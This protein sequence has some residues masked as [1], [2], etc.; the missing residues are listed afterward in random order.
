[1]NVLNGYSKG[2]GSVPRSPI[3]NFE[4]S[5]VTE[6]MINSS[7]LSSELDPPD[8]EVVQLEEILSL[9]CK[10]F[11]RRHG[12]RVILAGVSI[13]KESS[14]DRRCLYRFLQEALSIVGVKS[15]WVQVFG[16]IVG[17]QIVFVV[18]GHSETINEENPV[19]F[20]SLIEWLALFNGSLQVH[21]PHESKIRLIAQLPFKN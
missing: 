20:V 12:I 4:K 18:D 6:Q 11:E 2:Q 8:F 19:T 10:D 9:F 17:D 21:Y 5:F 7:K 16:M 1:M 13:F 15:R 14:E 3:P